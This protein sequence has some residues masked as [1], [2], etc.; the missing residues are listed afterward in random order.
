MPTPDWSLTTHL[1]FYS[2]R[3]LAWLEAYY[4]RS[5]HIVYSA[6]LAFPFL[7]AYLWGLLVDGF[8][9]NGGHTLLVY[10]MNLVASVLGSTLT[11]LIVGAGVAW[12]L[13]CCVQHLRKGPFRF[14][15][16]AYTL[17]L[18]FPLMMLEAAVYAFLLRT[19]GYMIRGGRF[20]ELFTF[21]PNPNYVRLNELLY[22]DDTLWE[23]IHG[24]IGAGFMEEFVFRVLLIR[25][26][27]FS[28]MG[29]DMP[30]GEDREARNNAV[31]L[32]SVIFAAV[33]IQQ[34]IG[35]DVGHL[36]F[37]MLGHVFAGVVFAIIYLHRGYGIAAVTHTTGNLYLGFGIVS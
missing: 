9:P 34:F 25:L 10:V 36:I 29:N 11:K 1:R 26:L 19:V 15:P 16:T 24:A 14:A 18:I 5:A 17:P 21:V 35:V 22:H 7:V 31:L 27:Y 3:L 8:D 20:P 28:S 12:A 33:H 2:K 37:G 6:I 30:F 23:M 32:S 4:E 13:Y